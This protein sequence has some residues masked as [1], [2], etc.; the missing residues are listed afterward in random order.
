MPAGLVNKSYQQFVSPLL[1]DQLFYLFP[2]QIRLNFDLEYLFLSNWGTR[3][4][5][6]L[7]QEALNVK[8]QLITTQ[9]TIE[10]GLPNNSSRTKSTQFIQN[11]TRVPNQISQILERP[12]FRPLFLWG[13][14]KEIRRTGPIDKC[15]IV[16]G[17]SQI[18]K[19]VD[20]GR[21]IR[22]SESI[23]KGTI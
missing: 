11:Q 17:I 14:K 4:K 20:F 22:L 15:E 16:S 8:L 3:A 7:S 13:R 1:M 21:K 12:I 6:V 23:D 10:P 9:L 18:E 2:T 19:K 5:R